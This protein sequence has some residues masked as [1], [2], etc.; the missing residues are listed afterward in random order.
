MRT[1]LIFAFLPIPKPIETGL[2]PSWK[3]GISQLSE[4]GAIFGK[5]V[6][7]TYG[8]FG[9]LVRG[10]VIDGNFWEIFLFQTFVHILLFA[11]TALRMARSR[12]L[13]E[14][15]AVGLSIIFPCLIAD[16]YQALQTEYKIL[17]IIILLL[18]FREIWEGRF[19]RYFA[20]GIGAVGGFL[21]HSKVS[22]ACKPP[23]P[24]SFS[25]PFASF[26]DCE[27][28]REFEKI[29]CCFSTPNWRRER[30]HFCFFPGKLRSTL[31]RYLF[32]Y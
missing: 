11:V 32:Y 1:V 16:V 27:A 13:V 20:I 25:S 15:I 12:H 10:A 31:L 4:N 24:S 29:C 2:D 19:A 23:F 17:Y 3:Y 5:D 9:Y 7:F 6:I 14:R 28:K 22:L 26:S 8:S 18:S 21:L 30:Q